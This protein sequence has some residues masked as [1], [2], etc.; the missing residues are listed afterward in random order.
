MILILDFGSQYTQLI[1]R[2]IREM[3]VYCE[4]YPGNRKIDEFGIIENVKGI[5]LSGGPSSVYDKNAPWPDE[6][7]WDLGVPILGICYGMQLIAEHHGGKVKKSKRREYGTANLAMVKREKLFSNITDTAV[8]MSHGDSLSGLSE[9]FS[10]LAKTHNSHYAA[11]ADPKRQI[12]G[13]QFHPEVKH[14][15][16]GKEMLWNFVFTICGSKAD[17]TMHN[18]IE[19]EIKR[20]KR[21]VGKGKV[22]CALSGGVD[23]SVASVLVHKAVG[24]QLICVFVDNG[25]L[26]SGEKQRVKKVF[27]KKFGKNLIIA[28][29]SRQFLSKLSGVTDPEKKRKIIGHEFISVFENE[30]KKIKNVSFLVQGTLY[31]D[32]IESVSVKGPSAVI[33]SHHNVG[34]LPEKMHLKLVEPLKFLFKDEVRV[35][36]KE[37]NVPSEVLTRHPFPGPGL[38]IRVLGEVTKE[39]LDILRK[40]DAIVEEEIRKAG[41]YEKLWQ[42]F[43][44]MLPVKTVGV[45]GD[46]RTYE[47]VVALR[48]VESADAMT[49][50]WARLPYELLGRMSNRIINEVRGVNR[51]VYDISQKPPATIEWE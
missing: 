24:K 49:A 2:R 1:A 37:L 30:A 18:F 11:I 23:S 35:L 34:G 4:I 8:W 12:Y 40:A 41:I 13:V 50:D 33:K 5:I 43:A 7:I 31:P 45:M 14:T 20:I 9:G 28:D 47:N 15:P 46:S 36:G 44:V 6:K 17:W 27:R 48:I 22:L 26:R 32:V 10:V 51:V 29:A 42:A 16:Q 25:V 3:K 38:A 21:Q 19:E 39:R